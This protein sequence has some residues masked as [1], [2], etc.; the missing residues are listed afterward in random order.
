MISEALGKKTFLAIRE[1]VSQYLINM[2]ETLDGATFFDLQLCYMILLKNQDEQ[3]IKSVARN[4]LNVVQSADIM[5]IISV[6]YLK[7]LSPFT[8][9]Y[10]TL[11][12]V[13]F[14]ALDS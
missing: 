6:F 9:V 11:D 5:G 4:I 3:S 7:S 13:I 14:A 12:V 1:V 8:F 2:S 10:D